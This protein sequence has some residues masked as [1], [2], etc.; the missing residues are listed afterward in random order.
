MKINIAQEQNS[1]QW[2]RQ[3]GVFNDNKGCFFL[4]SH[5]KHVTPHPNRQ[6]LQLLQKISPII[7]K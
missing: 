1:V 6:K 4:I 5:Q 7:T 3:E 2:S